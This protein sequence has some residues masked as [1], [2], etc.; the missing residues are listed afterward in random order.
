M[1]G[2]NIIIS[3]AKIITP[4]QVASTKEMEPIHGHFENLEQYFPQ[5]L[6]QRLAGLDM[7]TKYLLAAVKEAL[8]D[9]KLSSDRDIGVAIATFLGCNM[10]RLSFLQDVL[11]EKKKVA[12]PIFFKTTVPSVAAGAVAILCQCCG[13]TITCIGNGEAGLAALHNAIL[14]IQRGI[15]KEMIVGGYED[16]PLELLKHI[17]HRVLG[18]A[19]WR[20]G[21]AALILKHADVTTNCGEKALAK[22]CGLGVCGY[23]ASPE[24]KKQA[25]R[26]TMKSAM[27]SAGRQSIEGIISAGHFFLPVE[28][29]MYP[30]VPVFDTILQWGETLGMSGII[31][32]IVAIEKLNATEH[33]SNGN[34][35]SVGIL[36][37]GVGISGT[38]YSVLLGKNS[39]QI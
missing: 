34:T 39:P 3:G 38:A 7:G 35:Q 37:N 17:P 2:T 12:N 5:G 13:P 4:H 33:S 26:K 21:G 11:D 19:P 25:L 29:E 6:P 28:K 31:R 1:K 27:F 8:Q 30:D 9:F 23:G 14:L 20:E 18:A 32:L 10:S 22:I 16:L 36:V 24:Q 15:A